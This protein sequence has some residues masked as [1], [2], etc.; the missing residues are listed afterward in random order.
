MALRVVNS[1]GASPWTQTVMTRTPSAEDLIVGLKVTHSEAMPRVT[2][3]SKEGYDKAIGYYRLE[4]RPR[5]SEE[6][7]KHGN[8]VTVLS[9]DV[10][11]YL[12]FYKKIRKIV[13]DSTLW[14]AEIV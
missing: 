14:L 5:G 9:V 1:V 7:Q 6:W 13:L 3:R 2:W 10:I 4:W 12:T 8:Q 11:C